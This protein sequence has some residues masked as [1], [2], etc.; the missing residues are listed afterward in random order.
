MDGCIDNTATETALD[1]LKLEESNEDFV[2]PWNVASQ[3]DTGIDYDKLI[4]KHLRVQSLNQKCSICCVNNVY[5]EIIEFFSG[6]LQNDSEAQKWM[7][8]LFRNSNK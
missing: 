6:Y 3:S 1:A 2:D 5:I 7:M 8:Q 4:R